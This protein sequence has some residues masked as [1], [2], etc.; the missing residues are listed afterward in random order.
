M[1]ESPSE[2]V[3]IVLAG[4]QLVIPM[5]V[6]FYKRTSLARLAACLIMGSLP[7][8]TFYHPDAIYHIVM[9]PGGPSLEAQETE[10]LILDFQPP[11][12]RTRYI[13]FIKHPASVILLYLQNLHEY[14]F[15]GSLKCL[16]EFNIQQACRLCACCGL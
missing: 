6:R 15:L 10:L 4:C 3:N 8:H 14:T 7:L 11:K 2:R 16:F 1:R 13:F 5:R 9:Q 12:L